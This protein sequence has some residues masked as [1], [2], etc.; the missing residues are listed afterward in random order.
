MICFSVFDSYTALEA[1]AQERS[2]QSVPSPFE[3]RM[4]PDTL[5]EI[6]RKEPGRSPATAWFNIYKKLFPGAPLPLDPYVE[7]ML[8]SETV[9]NYMAFFEREAPGLLASEINTR[10]FGYAST[11]PGQDEFV[12]SLLADSIR[13]LLETIKAGYRS[14]R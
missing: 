13:V 1:H 11:V 3:E 7:D 10:M 6:K 14:G 9:Q 2:C 12:E 5:T 4:T 8:Q